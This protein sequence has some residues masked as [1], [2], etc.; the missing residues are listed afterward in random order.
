MVSSTDT[1]IQQLISCQKAFEEV[2]EL[3]KKSN[4]IGMGICSND[5]GDKENI[6]SHNQSKDKKAIMVLR[7]KDLKIS[8]L[9]EEVSRKQ[10]VIIG[11]ENTIESLRKL[12]CLQK[13]CTKEGI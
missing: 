12:L 8:Q 7:E 2:K 13:I 1:I 3:L 9:Q 6:P 5:P 11:Y 4:K 10:A